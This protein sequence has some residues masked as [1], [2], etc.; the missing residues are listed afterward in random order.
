MTETLRQGMSRPPLRLL[1]PPQ[2]Q[3]PQLPCLHNHGGAEPPSS[4]NLFL[5]R[6]SPKQQVASCVPA[7]P[8][9]PVLMTHGLL[10][11]TGAFLGHN[12]VFEETVRAA[13]GALASSPLSVSNSIIRAVLAHTSKMQKGMEKPSLL[14][15]GPWRLRL[16]GLPATA[17]PSI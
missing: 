11:L 2:A 12:S 7:S 8:G 15:H 6:V 9:R 4:S 3:L 10:T 13:A 1:P 16:P 17:L 14:F 5:S